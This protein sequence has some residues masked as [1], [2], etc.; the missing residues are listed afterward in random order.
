MEFSFATAT[1]ILFGEGV[2]DQLA[3]EIKPFGDRVLIVTGA[4]PSRHGSV[5]ETLA[6]SGKALKTFRIDEEPSIERIDE[7]VRFAR[8]AAV[9]LVVAIGGGS[10]IDAGKAIAA[11][12]TNTGDTIEYLEVIGGGKPL[13]EN[14]LP[15][16]AVP[17]TAGTGSEVTKNAVLYSRRHAVKVSLRSDLM[18]PRCALIDPQL[19]HAMPAQLT[20]NTGLDALTQVLEPYI[21]RNANPLTDA[22]CREG[23][24]RAAH[25]LPRVCAS[26]QDGE[27]RCDMALASMFGGL[28]LANAKLGAVHGF[29]GPLGGMIQAP[30]GLICAR[31][32]PI[33]MEVNLRAMQAREPQNPALERYEDIASMLTGE[34][35]VTPQ[36][37]IDWIGDLCASLD[38]PPLRDVGMGQDHIPVA[39]ASARKSSSMRGN[40]ILL[41][42]SEMAEILERAL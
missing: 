20:A 26:G 37:A 19:T 2:I 18:F 12:M 9:E 15:F 4:E 6:E 27:A 32:L 40:P 29:A 13:S 34:W 11:L 24:V 7:G 33:V 16:L 5:L 39:I 30:H 28:A 3:G 8:Q 17:T 42:D 14:P 31:L 23:I 35:D 38:I 22:I 36:D 41:T 10:V 21:S 25:A 1:R